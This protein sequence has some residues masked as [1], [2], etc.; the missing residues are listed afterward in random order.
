MGI[1]KFLKGKSN[2][3]NTN[4]EKA[5]EQTKAEAELKAKEIT[6]AEAKAKEITEAEAKAK[7]TAEAER[8]QFISILSTKEQFINDLDKDGDGIIDLVQGADEFTVLLNK[9]QE[10]IINKDEKY[11]LKFVQLGEFLKLKRNNIQELFDII[12]NNK[13]FTSLSDNNF[14]IGSI[15]KGKV[16]S[17]VVYG[18]FIE[19]SAGHEALLHVSE[20]A[21]ERV[22]KPED[23]LKLGQEIEVKVIGKDPRNGKLKISRKFETFPELQ[24]HNGIEYIP[25][26]IGVL[27]NTIH[28][29]EQILFHSLNMIIALIENNLIVFNKIYLLFDKLNVFNSNW[30]NQVSEK[31]DNIEGGLNDILNAIQQMEINIVSEI[32]N[33]SYITESSF[34]DLNQSLTKE[35]SSINSSINL[36][37]LLTGLQAYQMYKINKNTKSLRE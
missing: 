12:K 23:Y 16:K 15:H 11:I 27:Q 7:E 28:S 34:Q 22:E 5:K 30:E 35:L 10:R 25:D 32:S 33:L 4:D 8:K 36:N 2:S 6:E 29:Y 26:Y 14:T 19:F 37:N 21:W 9:Y 31:L 3:D 18:A 17:I 20:I 13:N 1:F 24:N